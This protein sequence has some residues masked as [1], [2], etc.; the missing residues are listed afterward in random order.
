MRRLPRHRGWPILS[1]ALHSP[2][3]WDVS[4]CLQIGR[5]QDCFRWSEADRAALSQISGCPV[6]V[7]I[8]SLVPRSALKSQIGGPKEADR[9]TAKTRIG[10]YTPYPCH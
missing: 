6:N 1:S 5:A 7:G 10:A 9:V 4:I 8:V 3:D 2:F